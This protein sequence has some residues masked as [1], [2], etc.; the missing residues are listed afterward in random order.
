MIRLI[1]TRLA[2]LLALLIGTAQN[3]HAADD[4]ILKRL[5]AIESRLNK[6]EKSLAEAK[7][8][9]AAD[10]FSALL[11]LNNAL[12][13]ASEEARARRQKLKIEQQKEE[14]E[15]Q[16]TKSLRRDKASKYLSLLEWDATKGIP[17]ADGIEYVAIFYKMKNLSSKKMSLIHGDIIFEDKLGKLIAKLKIEDDINL[18]AG[19]E[20]VFG[21]KKPAFSLGEKQ[22]LRLRK[23]DESLVNIHFDLDVIYFEDGSVVEF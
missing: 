14:E 3:A 21:T 16:R 6:I 20:R 15:K 22:A 9:A 18:N 1:S 19:E 8:T 2:L 23:L 17:S 4:E 7:P 10:A 11:E 5:D 12:T 13:G